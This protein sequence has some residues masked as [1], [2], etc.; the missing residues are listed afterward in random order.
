MT[1]RIPQKRVERFQAEKYRRVGASLLES[2]AALETVAED[3]DRFG[4]A[5]AIVAI[6]AA[7]AYAD[8]L[9]IAYREVKSGAGDHRAAADLLRDALGPSADARMVT[10]FGAIVANKD[11]VAYTGTFFRMNEA[12]RLLSEARVVCEWA[13]DLYARRPAG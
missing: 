10:R 6:H 11:R 9:A 7:I 1:R 8:A 4:N 13:E 12:L 5:I 3:D 2:A